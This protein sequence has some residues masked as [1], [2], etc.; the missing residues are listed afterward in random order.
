[1]EFVLAPLI[2]IAMH[3][4]E[5]KGIGLLYSNRLGREINLGEREV[6][7]PGIVDQVIRVGTETE[8]RGG[9]ASTSILPFRFRW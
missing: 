7:K 4:T 6:G 8:L 3:V 2:Y 1:M 5:P 9:A